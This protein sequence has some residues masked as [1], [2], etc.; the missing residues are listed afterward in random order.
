MWFWW[1]SLG[2]LALNQSPVRI[3][4]SY[5]TLADYDRKERSG[6]FLWRDSRGTR[7]HELEKAGRGWL[8]VVQ[9]STSTGW[10]DS[11]ELFLELVW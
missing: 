8:A 10:V 2:C 11:V 7:Y 5:N 9:Y 6:S 3:I 4:D 1:L